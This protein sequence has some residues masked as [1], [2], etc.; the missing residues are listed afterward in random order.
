LRAMELYG[1]PIWCNVAFG[2]P[3]EAWT[4]TDTGKSRTSADAIG[5]L[6]VKNRALVAATIRLLITYKDGLPEAANRIV[7]NDAII[8][9]YQTYEDIEAITTMFVSYSY[10]NKGFRTSVMN[11]LTWLCYHAHGETKTR[12]FLKILADGIGVEK[13]D[14]ARQLRERFIKENDARSKLT[15]IDRFAIAI[16]ALNAWIGNKPVQSLGW[17]NVNPAESFPK[18]SSK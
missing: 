8:R 5:I 15:Q 7:T 13:H 17:R 1:K 11:A 18:V 3:R 16:K 4:V 14:A 10:P 9:G 2:F 12:E 6:G